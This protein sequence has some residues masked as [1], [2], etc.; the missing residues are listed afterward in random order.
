MNVRSRFLVLGTLL[1]AAPLV[2]QESFPVRGQ[3]S[4][5]GGDP[6]SDATVE[7]IGTYWSVQSR[8][9]GLFELSLPGGMWH[10]RVSKIGYEPDTVSVVTGA[11]ATE[12][13]QL[14]LHAAA[15]EL[16]GI[17]VQAARTPALGQT[18]TPST[19]RQ[20][21]PLG[22]PDIFRAVV[23]LP[24]VSQP[25]DL[26][27]RI[28][29]AGGS[30]DETGVRLDG[31]PLQDPFHLLGL[32]GAFNVAALDRAD[33]LIHHLPA[34]MGGRLSG[35]VDL[36]TK[37]PGVEPEHEAVVSLLTSGFTASRPLGFGGLDV[38]AAGRITYLDKVAPVVLPDAPQ[39]GFAD[40]LVRVGG[41][42]EGG[43]RAEALGFTTRDRFRE[44]GFSG[45]PSYRPLTWGESLVGLRLV[46]TGSPWDIVTRASFNRATVH[47]DETQAGGSNRVESTRGWWSG[48]VDLSRSSEE[49]RLNTGASVDHRRNEQAWTARGLADEI[50]SPSTPA[51][52][53][54]N[55]A[56]TVLALFGEASRTLG[57]RWT[58]TAGGRLESVGGQTYF[59]PRGALGVRASDRLRLEAALDRRYQFDS[60]IE[61]P[62]EGS[63]SAPLFLLDEPRRADVAAVSADWLLP[64][65]PLGGTGSV[66]V[67]AF[68]K[69]YPD[70]MHLREPEPG[71]IGGEA[72]REFPDFE[73]FPGYSVGVAA[74]GQFTWGEE[75]I[76]QG[77]YTFQRTREKWD[78][79][80]R[81]TAWDAPHTLA[82]FGSVPLPKDWT[83]NAVYH[84][85]SG[86][87]T[88]PLVARI[89]EPNA[90]IESRFLQPRYLLG[91][92]NSIRVPP[93][94]RLD[95][96]ARRSWEAKGAQWTLSVQV[97]N[98]LLR[99]NAI[100]YDWSTYFSDVRGG[101]RPGGPRAGRTGLPLLPSIGLEVRW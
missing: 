16:R 21:P 10:L 37:Q 86:R 68:A 24:G 101:Q 85:H 76:V 29:L 82:L 42:W 100:D 19:V 53:A 98:A 39:L 65:P 43:W 60:Q 74:S 18:V 11:A 58:A 32:F 17:S 27:G 80:F 83:F 69:R 26:K 73:R 31:H 38:L 3:V 45:V 9:D 22:E 67:Q 54:G 93:Y 5:A 59:A 92:R 79:Q 51:E 48:A 70:R 97:L 90:E 49:W 33:V 2:A 64:R 1:T 81:P 44:P 75:G 34:S 6:V 30:S 61:E 99:E 96:G 55:E 28:H 46:R 14:R 23:L 13:L 77:S 25:N 63:V 89:F 94:H 20:V 47:L 78:G 4:A 50:F 88:T 36:R 91:E 72:P 71:G 57:G 40:A 84:A 52:F 7:V 62:I 12:P 87:A 35:V 8:P 41:S 66:R 56:Q 15:I 95:L